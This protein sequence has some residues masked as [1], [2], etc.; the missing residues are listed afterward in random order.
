MAAIMMRLLVDNFLSTVAGIASPGFNDLRCC[1]PVRAGDVLSIRVTVLKARRSVSKPEQGT[2][3]DQV[4]V[5]NQEREVV[6]SLTTID[7]LR[8]R[9]KT[10]TRESNRP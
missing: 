10:T 1:R 8:C 2:V 4:E 5:L 9:P 6:L 7:M 3:W